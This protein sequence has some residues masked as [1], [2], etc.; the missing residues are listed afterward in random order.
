M[1]IFTLI[2]SLVVAVRTLITIYWINLIKIIFRIEP[3]MEE[4]KALWECVTL[5]PDQVTHGR[6]VQVDNLEE[7]HGSY[8]IALN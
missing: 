4:P 8:G 2:R 6:N 5:T 3:M 7:L 1:V